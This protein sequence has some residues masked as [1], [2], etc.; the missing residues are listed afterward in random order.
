ML[1]IGDFTGVDKGGGARGGSAPPPNELKDHPCEKMKPRINC[2]CGGG[3]GDNYVTSNAAPHVMQCRKGIFEAQ[4]Y[5]ISVEI[6]DAPRTA[7]KSHVY[8]NRI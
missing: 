4:D 7:T 2:V 6:D 5:Q 8:V 3:G 1:T